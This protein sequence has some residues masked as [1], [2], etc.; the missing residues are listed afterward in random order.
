MKI[1]AGIHRRGFV[2]GLFGGAAAA[3]FADS[4]LAQTPAPVPCQ[5]GPPPHVK[6]PRVWMDMDQIERTLAIL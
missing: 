5:V 3:G 6:G 1:L 2:S 4:V